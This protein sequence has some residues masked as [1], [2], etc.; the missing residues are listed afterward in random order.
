VNGNLT[1]IVVG[2]PWLRTGTGR[3]IEAQI[4]YYRSRGCRT[5]F[6]GVAVEPEHVAQDPIWRRYMVAAGDLRAD[7]VSIAALLGKPKPRKPITRVRHLLR[8]DTALDWIVEIAS[9]SKLP[10]DAIAFARGKTPALIHVNHVYTLG[11]AQRLNMTLSPQGTRIPMIVET[12]DVQAYILQDR[13]YYNPWTKRLDSL[14]RL[15]R[16]E[17]KQL[18]AADALVHLSVEDHDFF[19]ARLPNK[20][21]ILAMPTLDHVLATKPVRSAPVDP[22]DLLFIGTAHVANLLAIEWLFT[23]VWPHIANMDLRL[24]VVGSIDELVRFELP[25]IYIAFRNCFVGPV[26]DVAPYYR[27]ARC[28][29]APMVSGRGISIKTIEAMAFGK[30]FV[31]TTKAFRGMP[32]DTIRAAGVRPCDDARAFAEAISAV[33]RTETDEGPRNRVLYER[34]FSQDTYFRSLDSANQAVGSAVTAQLTASRSESEKF[35]R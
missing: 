10:E 23:A 26:A 33:L 27:A 34:L 14:A 22:I 1:A 24:T 8:G 7:C 2:P 17:T 21:Q 13:K 29:I 18:A 28:V 9:L 30:P 15:I 3:V 6:I 32:M 4:A 20:P 11:F 25:H 35:D 31:G 19:A 5:I 12:H 16:S